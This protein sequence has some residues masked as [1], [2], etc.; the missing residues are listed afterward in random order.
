ML[1]PPQITQPHGFKNCKERSNMA[2]YFVWWVLSQTQM[3]LILALCLGFTPGRDVQS[4]V[5][6]IEPRL[7]KVRTLCLLYSL[8]S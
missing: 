8:Y 5:P 4:M 1:T 7:T 2:F 3:Y 6:G